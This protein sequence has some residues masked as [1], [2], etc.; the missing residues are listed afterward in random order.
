MGDTVVAL[1]GGGGSGGSGMIAIVALVI[2]AFLFIWMWRQQKEQPPVAAAAPNTPFAPILGGS[3][4][5][6]PPTTVPPNTTPPATVPPITS[7]NCTTN[8]SCNAFC[9][10]VSMFNM[11]CF[12]TSTAPTT[13]AAEEELP[14]PNSALCSS[15]FN[16]SCNTECGAN[17][18]LDECTECNAICDSNVTYTGPDEPAATGGAAVPTCPA[19]YVYNAAQNLC[20]L[21]TA[22][23][24]VPTCPPGYSYNATYNVCQ[25]TT[26]APVVPTPTTTPTSQ[27]NPTRCQNEFNGS[28][29]TECSSGSSSE[30]NDCM[31]ACGVAT[32]G[33][34]SSGGTSGG[35]TAECSSKYNGSCNTE[36]SSGGTT[37]CNA[38]KA[39]CGL[40]A[41]IATV[42]Y[43]SNARKLLNNRLYNAMK[44]RKYNPRTEVSFGYQL[45]KM[46]TLKIGNL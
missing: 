36:C 24:A 35:R 14:D 28:C 33:G 34:A 11:C 42:R 21:S 6:P 23:P 25:Q 45:G 39:A 22:A 12:G 38:C 2:V 17:G 13:P 9:N 18:D 5:A 40:S 4:N 7:C 46:N 44:A 10:Q 30:C 1:S 26:A 15:Q 27:A 37:T 20:I 43:A 41:N 3:P 32:A 8:A 31:I 16:G 19:G 29:N